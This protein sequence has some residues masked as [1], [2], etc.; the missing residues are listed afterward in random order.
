M[1]ARLGIA[2]TVYSFNL[3]PHQNLQ[4]RDDCAEN[5]LGLTQLFQ[6]ITAYGWFTHAHT[7]PYTSSL[8]DAAMNGLHCKEAGFLL[9]SR[10]SLETNQVPVNKNMS[11]SQQASLK[12][13]V[14]LP[15]S[16][17]ALCRYRRGEESW[18]RDKSICLESRL[19]LVSF[20]ASPV[21]GSQ[22]SKDLFCLE[23]CSGAPFMRMSHISGQNTPWA[24]QVLALTSP[25]KRFDVLGK[26]FLWLI[27]ATTQ[28]RQY[29]PMVWLSRRQH[30][31]LL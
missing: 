2:P 4:L 1:S 5:S 26:T 3:K 13:S 10:D 27:T 8:G 15:Q 16:F 18:L 25:V 7:S 14:A 31:L 23:V 20:P 11:N 9:F 21:K 30:L 19:L 29:G 28:H 22:A 6:K 17:F 24:S 12:D